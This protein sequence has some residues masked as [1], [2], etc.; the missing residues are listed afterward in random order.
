MRWIKK[1]LIFTASGEGGWMNSHAQ[2]PSVLVM[3]DRLRIY[4][5]S[6]RERT[7][8][9]TTFLDVD[10]DDPGRIL[11]LHETPI[12]E[13]GPPGAFDEHGVMPSSVLEHEGRVWLYYGGWS[14]RASIPYSNWTGLAWSEDGGRTFER[15]FP[16]PILDRTPQEIFSAT[17]AFVVKRPGEWRMWYASGTEWV[18]VDG[19]FEE[20]YRI[21][22]ALSDDGVVWRRDDRE[23]LPF[24]RTREPTH[25]PSVIDIDGLWRMW[26]SHRSVED[27]R[28]GAGA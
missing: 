18:D 2:I 24:A 26:F 14:R 15:A 1:G 20:I 10:R 23:L 8:S 11:Y 4:F 16:G 19:K 25:R 3:K 28:G 7:L 5:S 6:R 9:L 17:A 22:A 27:F 12:L 21:R 13:P